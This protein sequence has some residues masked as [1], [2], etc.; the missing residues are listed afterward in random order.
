MLR[1]P[2]GDWKYSQRPA[3]S[4]R[5]SFYETIFFNREDRQDGAETDDELGVREQP[6]LVW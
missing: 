3:D 6:N 4:K 5:Y 1:K 2:L